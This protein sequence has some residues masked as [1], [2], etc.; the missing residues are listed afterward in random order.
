MQVPPSDWS[1]V[2]EK[3]QQLGGSP[4]RIPFLEHFLHLLETD[5]EL[6][7]GSVVVKIGWV[8]VIVKDCGSNVVFEV[9]WNGKAVEI[10]C[11]VNEYASSVVALI[12]D[13]LCNF[14][15][16]PEPNWSLHVVPKRH[17]IFAPRKEAR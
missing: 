16:T 12:V 13:G 7:A 1:H 6:S 10:D 5:I 3:G 17:Q 15:Q 2:F 8:V 11:L 4:E 14:T 9:D